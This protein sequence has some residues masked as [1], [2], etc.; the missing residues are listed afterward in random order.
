M[1]K[2]KSGAADVDQ[3]ALLASLSADLAQAKIELGSLQ[4]EAE[5]H[6][7]SFDVRQAADMRA[8]ERWRAASPQRELIWPD[9]ADMVVWLLERLEVA[10]KDIRAIAPFIQAYNAK[11]ETLRAIAQE[12]AACCGKPARMCGHDSARITL[13]ELGIQIKVGGV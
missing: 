13:K 7:K 12:T 1:S 4:K 11:I 10:D 8:I 3:N 6:E 9:H 5:D 2:T